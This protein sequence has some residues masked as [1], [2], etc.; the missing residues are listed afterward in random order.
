MEA[1]DA[2]AGSCTTATPPALRTASRPAAPSSS[3]PDSTK[4]TTRRP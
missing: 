1:A 4:P 2:S 3:Q